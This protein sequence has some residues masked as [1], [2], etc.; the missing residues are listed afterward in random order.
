[1]ET[2]IDNMKVKDFAKN[3]I[4][5]VRAALPKEPPRPSTEKIQDQI[6]ALCREI[7]KIAPGRVSFE[8]GMRVSLTVYRGYFELTE[9]QLDDE[10]GR[11]HTYKWIRLE[12]MRQTV[13]GIY[14]QLKQ[15]A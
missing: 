6:Y 13:L 11:N 15:A 4:R 14:N 12:R 10:P 1:M 7:K 8:V 3:T 5:R 2:Q 9:L